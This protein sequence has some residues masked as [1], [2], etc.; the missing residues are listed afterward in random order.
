MKVMSLEGTLGA[1]KL[2]I[3]VHPCGI[4]GVG[5]TVFPS[6]EDPGGRRVS[7][8]IQHGDGELTDRFQIVS[9]SGCD[10]GLCSAKNFLRPK[11]SVP[12]A[13]RSEGDPLSIRGPAWSHIVEV[14]VRKRESIAAL[15]RHHPQL[16][17]LL[18]QVRCVQDPLSVRREIRSRLPSRLFVVDLVGFGPRLGFHPPETTGTVNVTAVGNKKDFRSI[19]RP[20]WTDLVVKRAVVITRQ[21]SAGFARQALYILELA[22]A[23]LPHKDVEMALIRCGNEGDALSV[24][25]KSRFHVSR[26]APGKLPRSLTLEV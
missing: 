3:S 5:A 7:G 9:F 25:R 10:L 8:G 11:R 24:G 22:G 13:V 6:N 18:S 16:V 15:S 21:I 12:T 26:S 14:T 17:P 2:V 23:K 4:G 20:R 1:D 19:R